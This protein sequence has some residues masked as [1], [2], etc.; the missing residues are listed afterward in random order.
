MVSKMGSRQLTN[1]LGST[2][3]FVIRSLVNSEKLG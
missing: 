3:P 1:G 2:A